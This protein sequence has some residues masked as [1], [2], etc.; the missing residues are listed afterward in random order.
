MLKIPA[1]HRGRDFII[2][3]V[4]GYSVPLDRLLQKAKVRPDHDRVFFVGDVVDRGPDS[5][6]LLERV[7]QNSSWMV[8]IRGNHE[9]DLIHSELN[10]F[11]WA[12]SDQKW[13]WNLNPSAQRKVREQ[14]SSWPVLLELALADGRHAGL[15]HAEVP[16]GIRWTELAGRLQ[17]KPDPSLKESLQFGR[18]RFKAD[19][20]LRADPDLV[21][22][23]V[24]QYAS[25]CLRP[26][27]GIDVVVSGHSR[28]KERA[29]RGRGN[30]YWIDTGVDQ[31]DGLLTMIDLVG[32][33]YYQSGHK[34][35][36]TKGPIALPSPDPVT[37]LAQ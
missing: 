7:R 34:K 5:L 32:G 29:P 2:G 36:H 19:T 12:D 16:P 21:V 26:V 8:S 24:R 20:H 37:M 15:V 30:C 25:E 22:D 33:V 14:L 28:L 10:V 1:N 13:F 18:T 35:S 3:D 17:D 11:G 6:G 27:S 31:A 23:R 4:H 9:E